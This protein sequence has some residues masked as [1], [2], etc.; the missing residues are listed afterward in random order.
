MQLARIRLKTNT[1]NRKFLNKAL[2]FHAIARLG[3]FSL[4]QEQTEKCISTEEIYEAL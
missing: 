2:F 3:F 1:F 4:L